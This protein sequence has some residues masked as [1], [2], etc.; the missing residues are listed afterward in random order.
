MW[1]IDADVLE[2]S[3]YNRHLDAYFLLLAS[4]VCVC[5]QPL[6]VGEIIPVATLDTSDPMVR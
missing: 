4:C 5:V 3:P 1:C 6:E 2:E